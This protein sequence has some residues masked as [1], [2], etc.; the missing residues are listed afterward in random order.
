MN[1]ISILKHF[2]RDIIEKNHIFHTNRDLTVVRTQ[3]LLWP[4]EHPGHYFNIILFPGQCTAIDVIFFIHF[5]RATCNGIIVKLQ[6]RIRCSCV[7][8]E[9]KPNAD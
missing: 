2:E 3:K 6:H 1:Q 8:L 9:P 7:E 4:K 5:I